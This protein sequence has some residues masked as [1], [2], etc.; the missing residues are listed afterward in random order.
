MIFMML[1]M[2]MNITIIITI[3]ADFVSKDN[4]CAQYLCCSI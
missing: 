3:I 1:K 2:M 4:L